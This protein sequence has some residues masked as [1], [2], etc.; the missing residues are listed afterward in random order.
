MSECAHLTSNTNFIAPETT[1]VTQ[2][3]FEDFTIESDTEDCM[4]PTETECN[5]N[6]LDTVNTNYHDHSL[7]DV[8]LDQE[9]ANVQSQESTTAQLIFTVIENCCNTIPLEVLQGLC[10]SDK[11]INNGLQVTGVSY[12]PPGRSPCP[13]RANVAEGGPGG[14]QPV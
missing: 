4:L 11:P 10:D 7:G 1:S 6:V 9:P 8:L 3:L 5:P 14:A 2:F 12:S 13:Y